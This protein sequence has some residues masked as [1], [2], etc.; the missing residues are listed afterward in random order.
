MVNSHGFER[1]K[2]ASELSEVR[3]NWLCH[4]NEDKT[5]NIFIFFFD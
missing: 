3:Q 4:D 2:K 1:E 5:K